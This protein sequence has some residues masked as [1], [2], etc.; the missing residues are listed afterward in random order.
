MKMQEGIV[1]HILSGHP[2]SRH[3]QSI[4]CPGE[5]SDNAEGLDLT[6]AILSRM[7]WREGSVGRQLVSDPFLRS[8]DVETRDKERAEFWDRTLRQEINADLC[9]DVFNALE[10]EVSNKGDSFSVVT[11]LQSSQEALRKCLLLLVTGIATQPEIC[12]VGVVPDVVPLNSEAQWVTQS[13]KKE[14]RPF[15]DIG[16]DGKGQVIGIAD[17][18][19]DTDNCYFWDATGD[20]PKDGVSLESGL[21]LTRCAFVCLQR[22]MRY[23]DLYPYVRALICR[24]EKSC[25]M[26]PEEIKVMS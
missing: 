1:D 6:N 4:F 9:E 20:I 12:W 24:G 22:N 13:R 8:G 10:I 23:T 15:F 26:C 17:T 7:N 21:Y 5:A 11:A 16:L 3:F 2:L 19:L 18:G 14:S 25:N